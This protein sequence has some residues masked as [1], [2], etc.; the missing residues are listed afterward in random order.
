M[1]ETRNIFVLYRES[2]KN[3]SNDYFFLIFLIVVIERKRTKAINA[4]APKRNNHFIQ[5]LYHK[6]QEDKKVITSLI[7]LSFY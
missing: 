5:K 3:I 4:K 6:L 2:E 7:S 1:N